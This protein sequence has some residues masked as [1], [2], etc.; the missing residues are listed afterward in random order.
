MDDLGEDERSSQI[1]NSQRA[2]SHPSSNDTITT[3]VV[4]HEDDEDESD[5]I[6]D[7]EDDKEW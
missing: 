2:A 6:N 3:D 4:I 1:G 7:F 5:V